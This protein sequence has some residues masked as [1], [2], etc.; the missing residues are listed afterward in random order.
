MRTQPTKRR[1]ALLMAPVLAAG[2]ALGACGGDDDTSAAAT[3][4]PAAS[5]AP[6]TTTG[7]DT[8]AAVAIEDVEKFCSSAVGLEAAAATF[9]GE[10]EDAE[11]NKAFAG[12]LVPF[13]SDMAAS[14]PSSIKPLVTAV[15][16]V[17]AT[18]AESG[19]V[20]V[21]E[22]PEFTSALNELHAASLEGCEWATTDVEMKEYHFM[23]LPDSLPSGVMS[24]ELTNTGNEPHVIEI[25]RKNDG[26]TESFE[27]LLALSQEEAFAKVTS[28]GSGFAAPGESSYVLVDFAPGEYLAL[29]PLPIGWVDMSGP[30][31]DAAPHFTEG[32][33]HEFTVS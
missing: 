28:V 10:E 18:A 29:C 19:D 7:G 6:A 1:V 14:A 13:L 16:P 20:S 24:F 26:V 4:A 21:F 25:V 22:A 32:M 27:E 5:D 33:S 3:D 12:S 2:L 8:T 30:P 9:S 15:A 11:A 31:P 17:V 23:G